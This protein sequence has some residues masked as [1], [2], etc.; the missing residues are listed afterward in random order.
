LATD[1]FN[2]YASNTAAT[3]INIQNVLGDK[4]DILTAGN[5]I[6][7][8]NNVISATTNKMFVTTENIASPS[9]TP[10]NLFTLNGLTFTVL[11]AN[12]A[13]SLKVSSSTPTSLYGYVS[14]R[15]SSTLTPDNKWTSFVNETLST[16]PFVLYTFSNY[17]VISTVTGSLDITLFYGTKAMKLNILKYGQMY[18]KIIADPIEA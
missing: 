2:N 17:E 11:A 15:T 13:V 18:L 14:M 1:D 3:L 6:T 7:I 4:Q 12:N 8:S 5:N 9:D 10:Y 16:T